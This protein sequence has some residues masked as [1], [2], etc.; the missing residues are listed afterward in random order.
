V[1]CVAASDKEGVI[2]FQETLDSTGF[3]AATT[4]N[5]EGTIEVTTKR[6][7]DLVSSQELFLFKT[8]TQGFEMDVLQ[9]A[10][11]VLSGNQVFLLLVEFS[12]GLLNRAG[13]D[14]VTLL[15]LIYDL[16]FVCTYM[17]VHTRLEQKDQLPPR[18]SI[19]E[20][21]PDRR[22]SEDWISFEAFTES[23]RVVDAPGAAGVS[24]WSDLLCLKPC[25]I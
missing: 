7:D 10:R 12:Y 24:G 13:T 21:Y 9:G 20:Y 4:T 17:A 22:S 18:Y 1:H 2:R 6:V 5:K 14:P 19:V 23:L 25:W 15:N 8:D 3:T 16:G 11:R